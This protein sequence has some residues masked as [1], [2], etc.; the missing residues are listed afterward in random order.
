MKRI[1]ILILSVFYFAFAFSQKKQITISGYVKDTISG[2]TIIGANIYIINSNIGTSTNSYG[3]YSLT[4]PKTKDNKI[5]FSFIGYESKVIS[6]KN[7]DTI[8]NVKLKSGIE[9]DEVV[10]TENRSSNIIRK[11]E[12]S[13]THLDVKDIKKLP[14]LFGEVDIIKAFQLTPGVQSGGEGKNNLYVR[15]GSPDQNLYLLDDVPLYYVGH[16]AGFLSVFNADAINDVK[17]IKG[18]FPAQYGSRLSSVLD[19]RM[20]EGNVQKSEFQSTIGLLSSKLSI[21]SPLIK[22]KSS[23]IISARGNPIPIFKIIGAPIDYYFYDVNAKINYIFSDNNRIFLSFYKG[24]DCII[25]KR[26]SD[27]SKIKNSVAWGNTLG[28]FRWNH[29]Y[30]SKLFSNLTISDTYYRYKTNMDFIYETDSTNKNISDHLTSGINDVNLKLDYSYHLNSKIK[31][32]FGFN[33]IYHIYTPNNETYHNDGT[34]Y[35]TIDSVFSS[36][37]KALENAIY[38]ENHLRFNAFTSNIGVRFSNYNVGAKNYNYVEPRII[39]NY[40]F[41]EDFSIKYSFSRMNQYV[42]LLSYSGTGVPSDYWMPT[43]QNVKP[44][45]S[46]QHTLG[47]SKTFDEGMFELTVEAYHKTMNNLISLVSGTSIS[48]NLG[49]W[50]NLIEDGGIGENYGL[51]LFFQK[52]EGNTTGWIGATFA[53][54]FRQFDNINNGERYFFKYDR[55]FDFS[56]VVIQKISKNIDMSATWTYGSGYPITIAT[57][58]Y[59]YNYYNDFDSDILIYNKKNSFRMRDY[60]RLDIAINFKKEK[61]WGKR[62]WS[63]SIFNV[64]NRKNPYYYYYDRE[65]SYQNGIGITS[66]EPTYSNMKLYQRS[67]FSFFPSVAYSFK[68]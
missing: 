13:V 63:V 59:G 25:D 20:K 48:G 26:K 5:I 30:N 35:A 54:A 10:I 58:K 14:N 56:I 27:I 57:Q 40:I 44:E 55:L 17:L 2:E 6:I 43:T 64:Y 51:E 45:S 52:K 53:R 7:N 28:A 66:T 12:T 8:I 1:S 37:T 68:F 3:F 65:I 49:N 60:H 24:D 38:I 19:I 23:F 36:K 4:F 21:S 32:K 50:E 42:H 11:N 34:G 46:I 31:F 29:I 41:R 18:G 61:K 15:G 9:L 33:S 47:F 67:L 39:L 16:F 22:N 62:I